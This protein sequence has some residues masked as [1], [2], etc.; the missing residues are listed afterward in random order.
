M[1][2][3][4]DIY[5]IF[6]TAHSCHHPSEEKHVT[7]VRCRDWVLPVVFVPGVMGSN[8]KNTSNK[9]KWRVDSVWSLL[10]WLWKS[11]EARQEILNPDE[12]EV[13]PEGAI[14]H[15]L[16]RSWKTAE[17]ET[18][19]NEALMKARGW[20]EL[21]SMV[22]G[23]FL[24]WLENWLNLPDDISA[25][26]SIPITQL[27]GL[28]RDDVSLPEDFDA[29]VNGW[30][31]TLTR[32]HFPVHACGYNWLQSNADSA[33]ALAQR[34]DAIIDG[35][36]RA[37]MGCDRVI[38]LTHSMGGLVARYY[39]EVDG[40]NA[41][42]LG[43]VHGV[44][45][46]NGA[47]VFYRRMKCGTEGGFFTSHIMGATARETTAV[48]GS[49]PG[50]LQLV[51]TPAY[52]RHWL[53]IRRNGRAIRSLP[54]GD[55]PYTAIYLERE[56]WWGMLEPALANPELTGSHAPDRE[57]KIQREWDKYVKTMKDK[58]KSFHKNMANRF[59][60]NTYLFYSDSPDH[61]SYGAVIWQGRESEYSRHLWKAAQS[62]PHYN[63]YRLAMETD[64]HGHER[65]YRYEI[66]EPEDPGDGTVPSRSGRA[67][68]E[69]ARRTL[70]VATEHQS[71]Y[72]NAEARWFV[73]GAILEMAQQW[74]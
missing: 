55:D 8:L 56:Q 1:S 71:A 74:Q 36:R 52:G 48:L 18:I 26:D 19:P 27:V 34:V 54:E 65:V 11:P 61:M 3:E 35:Y 20:G 38:L 33:D 14:P 25:A 43:V 50:P 46:T 12:T 40:G 31:K 17:G 68:A 10:G 21:G 47:P 13:D 6:D 49:A 45:P 59:N 37:G 53:Q 41:S 44:M 62:R 63:Q 30:L 72:D 22:Y 23:E 7:R 15:G 42:M 66:G 32:Y 73:L 4:Y 5:D 60:P 64:R 2:D 16:N 70:A 58:V 69:H 51:P 67:G 28:V 24:V 9:E 57:K 29:T 39:S